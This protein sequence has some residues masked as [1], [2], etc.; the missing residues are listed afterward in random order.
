MVYA[1]DETLAAFVGH[2]SLSTTE[3]EDD[4]RYGGE[5]EAGGLPLYNLRM[6]V[7]IYAPP[8]Y[9]PLGTPELGYAENIN[10]LKRRIMEMAENQLQ[11]HEHINPGGLELNL[12]T[13]TND[14]WVT[15]I[16]EKT[17]GC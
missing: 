11:G 15:S 13:K 9:V 3:R 5:L 6:A 17:E 2:S 14:D 16:K 4:E 7:S 8:G 1:S 10:M 12:G